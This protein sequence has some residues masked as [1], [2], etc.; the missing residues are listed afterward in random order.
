MKEGFVVLG[1]IALLFG[2]MYVYAMTAVYLNKLKLR[3][4]KKRQLE[5]EAILF[6]EKIR[7][8]EI[9]EEKA[10]QIQLRREEMDQQYLRLNEIRREL[11]D[12][13]KL[14]PKEIVS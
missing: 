8:Q 2:S 12:K 4:E 3:R 5:L 10:K 11:I 14:K 9:R 6:D 1:V 7:K 13:G